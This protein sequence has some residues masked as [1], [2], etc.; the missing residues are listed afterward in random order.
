VNIAVAEAERV[1]P[2]PPA[3]N[4]PGIDRT[5]IHPEWEGTPTLSEIVSEAGRFVAASSIEIVPADRLHV[6]GVEAVL[7]ERSEGSD[8]MKVVA[9]WPGIPA[10]IVTMGRGIALSPYTTRHVDYDELVLDVSDVNGAV[11]V[12][13]EWLE[14]F[15]VIGVT[16]TEHRQFEALISSLMRAIDTQEGTIRE[17]RDELAQLRAAAETIQVQLRAPRPGRRVLGWALGQINQIPA[18]LLVGL[19]LPHLQELLHAFH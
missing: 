14:T 7:V 4:P 10:A 17:L 9:N 18:G 12:V 8:P 13:L 1:W 19:E 16:P 2:T 3:T 5:V 15:V 11:L 6:G